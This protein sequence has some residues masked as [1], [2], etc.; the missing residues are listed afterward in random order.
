VRRHSPRWSRNIDQVAADL[1]RST[2]I[3]TSAASEVMQNLTGYVELASTISN[4]DLT[5]LR[6]LR[7]SIETALANMKVFRKNVL[8]NQKVRTL[9]DFTRSM[10]MLGTII[11]SEIETTKAI[12]EALATIVHLAE[13]KSPSKDRRDIQAVSP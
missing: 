12:A 2:A 11:D 5:L 9:T 4:D 10:R 1:K 13:D 8:D 6:Q 7:E 3:Y